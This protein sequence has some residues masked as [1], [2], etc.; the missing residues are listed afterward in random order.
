M[1]TSNYNSSLII[2]TV[3][4]SEILEITNYQKFTFYKIRIILLNRYCGR[5]DNFATNVTKCV[6]L[7]PA[8]VIIS[9]R[10]ERICKS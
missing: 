3:I 6:Q 2:D 8:Q 9:G 1:F 10:E 7:L 5:I 4:S